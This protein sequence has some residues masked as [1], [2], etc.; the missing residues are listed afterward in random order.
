VK[1][2]LRK[3]GW[4]LR[5]RDRDAD[6]HAELEFHLNEETEAREAAGVAHTDARFAARRELGNLGLVAENT[7][8]AW[9]WTLLEQFAQDVRYALRMIRQNR[10]FTA[11]AVLSLALGIGA[12]TA[13][14]SFMDAILL[15]SLP[16][17]NP[18]SLA[19][20]NWKMMHRTRGSVVHSG[21]GTSYGNAKTGIESGIFPYPAYEVLRKS[22]DVFSSLFA[23]YPMREINVMVRQQAEVA[24]GEFVSGEY[25]GALGITPAAGRLIDPGDDREETAAVA[26]LSYECSRRRF[27][28]AAAAVGQSILINNQPFTVIGVTPPEFFG[29]EPS[30]SPEV[31]TPFH[32]NLLLTPKTVHEVRQSYLETNYYWVEMMGRL[33]PSVSIAQAQAL[34]A[35][36]FQQWVLSTAT[37][38]EER[39]ALPS[40]WVREGASGLDRLRREYSKPLYVLL[41]MVALILAIACA[42]IANLLLAR[43][44]ARRREI[45]VRL[46]M[47]AGRFRVIR[48]LLTE[49]LLLASIGGAVGVLF[50]IWG[51]RFLTVLLVNGRE[52]YTV[53]AELNWHVLAAA[54]ALSMLTGILFGLIPAIQGTKMDV[55]PVLKEVRGGDRRP[56][57]RYHFL[58]V[59]LSQVLVVSQIAISLLMLVAAGLFVRT[60]SNLES[61]TLGFNREN[62]LL[63]TLNAEQAGHKDAERDAFYDQLQR[64]LAAIPGVL[65]AVAANSPLVGRGSWFT[66]AEPVGKKPVVNT[67]VLSAGAGYLATMQIPLIA[68]RDFNEYD[69]AGSPAVAIVNEAWAKANF[70][71]RNPVGAY[72]EFEGSQR[73]KSQPMQVVGL[74]GNIRYGE[75]KGDYPATVYVPFVQ[76]TFYPSE[77]MTYALRTTGDP[78]R[79]VKAVREIVRQA[80]THVPVTN[81]RTQAASVDR[82]INQE[83]IFARLCTGFAVL[84]LVIACIGLYGTMAYTVARRTGEIGIRMALGARRGHV[85]GMVMAQVAVMA[86]VGLAIGVPVVKTL[87]KLVESFLYQVKP[88][89]SAALWIAVATLVFAAA[90]AGYGPAWRASRIDPMEALR[91]D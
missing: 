29:L 12:N 2:F 50:A 57:V 73:L 15:R 11:L 24:H 18:E 7:R 35:P 51:V 30:E 31:F 34:L 61:I 72:I 25:F 44:T 81:V 1:T 10:A 65:G 38:D 19:L 76:A 71:D 88:D 3:L 45:A 84:A 62:L 78:L 83:I 85:V 42:N 55:M 26:V 43:A 13:I 21:S 39:S 66:P 54:A 49:S 52:G 28:D 14:Y 91:H 4:L 70:G 40:L 80:D 59:S 75:I 17:S 32:A 58:R 47:G 68:G 64:R 23:Y 33:R 90:I 16:V 22:N 37:T 9:G 69:R 5:R 67:H 74:T 41:A 8:A 79:Y 20:M 77:E 63:F 27:G 48:Q 6:L 87:S 46:S 89:D 60:L 53:R 86:V 36:R 56:R 82:V